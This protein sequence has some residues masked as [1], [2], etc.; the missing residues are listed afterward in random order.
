GAVAG[1]HGEPASKGPRVPQRRK[2]REGGQED[3]LKEVVHVVAR[4]ACEQNSVDHPRIPFVE[5]L[6]GSS[7]PPAGGFGPQKLGRGFRLRRRRHEGTLHD[8]G[9]QVKRQPKVQVSV[10]TRETLR[11]ARP[12]TS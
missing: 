10:S 11:G 7:V 12:L 3:V 2:A 9:R 4:G 5:P 6:E 8:S 1:D